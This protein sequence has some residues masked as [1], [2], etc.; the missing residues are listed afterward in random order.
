MHFEN[1]EREIILSVINDVAESVSA[2]RTQLSAAM[3]T[4]ID[5]EE[6]TDIV[7]QHVNDANAALAE[8]HKTA[9]DANSNFRSAFEIGEKM[10]GA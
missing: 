6:A 1:N 3:H 2:T 10:R 8:L 7:Q 4:D 9:M 5:V